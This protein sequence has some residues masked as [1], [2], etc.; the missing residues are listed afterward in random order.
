MGSVSWLCKARAP[1]YDAG[2]PVGS[3]LHDTVGSTLIEIN[4]VILVTRLKRPP[5]QPK[6]PF[7]YKK[8]MILL[9]DK[10]RHSWDSI[11]ITTS[12]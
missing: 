11:L 5:L 2:S 1:L 7:M 4:G 3:Q 12:L 9:L 10:D 8:K 6:P